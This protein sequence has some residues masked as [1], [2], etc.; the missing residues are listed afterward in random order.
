MP[1]AAIQ[2]QEQTASV[3]IKEFLEDLK[4]VG[5]VSDFQPTVVMLFKRI[6]ARMLI[7]DN[8]HQ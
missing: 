3:S 7:A 4:A 1:R 5:R 8:A 6:S 2:E